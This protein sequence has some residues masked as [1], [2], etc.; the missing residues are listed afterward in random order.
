V[1]LHPQ[2]AAALSAQRIRRYQGRHGTGFNDE[3]QPEGWLFPAKGGA[4]Q[5]SAH[6][7]G[8]MT[9][10][11]LPSGWSA[12]SLRHAFATAAY[13]SE[14]DLRAVQELL[15]HQKPET[16]ARY[17]AVPDGA[18]QAAVAGTRWTRTYVFVQLDDP[19]QATI[20]IWL[21]PGDVR[22]R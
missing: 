19:R 18:L 10:T 13:A 5:L 21:R 16:T 7:I 3:A 22:R 6:W 9:G 1:P 15:G 2:L 4:A 20:G 14:R 17:A 12:H 8:K 11:A